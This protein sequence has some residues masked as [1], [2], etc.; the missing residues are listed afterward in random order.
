MLL[1]HVIV[2]L[3][4]KIS[5]LSIF[6]YFHI[7]QN[8]KNLVSLYIKC[9]GMF[10]NKSF[11]QINHFKSDSSFPISSDKNILYGHHIAE[12]NRSIT[13]ENLLLLLEVKGFFTGRVC[14]GCDPYCKCIG[15]DYGVCQTKPSTFFF[16]KKAWSCQGYGDH[17][18]RQKNCGKYFE[19]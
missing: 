15:R 19:G 4:M 16:Q 17:G 5:K 13:L 11:F 10:T 9:L 6:L 3:L 12:N 14:E 2:F 1:K 8:T 7:L 18:P